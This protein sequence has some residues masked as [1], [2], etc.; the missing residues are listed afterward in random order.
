MFTQ[1]YARN[2][3][4]I[5]LPTTS[6]Y[7]PE[8]YVI[9][10]WTATEGD[11]SSPIASAT[12][13]Q[14]RTLYA[15]FSKIVY[16]DFV[17][18][19]SSQ[20]DWSGFYLIVYEETSVAYD[21]SLSSTYLDNTPNTIGV[22]ITS[23]TIEHNATTE[24]SM[25]K[26]EKNNSNY[27]IRSASGYYI[28]RTESSN[29]LDID[30]NTKYNHTISYSNNVVSI[31]SSGGPTLQFLKSGDNSKFRY[32]ASTQKAVALYKASVSYEGAYTHIYPS[33]A[34]A[35]GDINVGSTGPM[36]IENGGTLNM[37][38]NTLTCTDPTKLVIEDG[39]QLILK[40][41]N[42]NVQA[43][44]KK[45]VKTW[46]GSVAEKT[47]PVNDGWQTISTST[48][49][50][51]KGY[52]SFSNVDNLVYLDNTTPRYNVYAYDEANILW[53][54]NLAS[55]P[56]GFSTLNVGQGYIYRTGGSTDLEYKG[57]VNTGNIEV[58][59][60]YGCATSSFKGFNLIGNP[61]THTIYKGSAVS[62]IPNGTLLEE[63]YYA[64]NLATGTFD[65]TADGT[66]I[67]RGTAIMVQ[68]IKQ[69]DVYDAKD[70]TLTIANSVNGASGGKAG[71]DNIWFS[72]KNEDF[73]DFACVKF[74]PGRGLNKIDHYNET[75]PMLYINHNGE[76]FGAVNMSDDTKSINLNFKAMTMGKYTL[77]LKPEGNF[78]YIHLIDKLTG[79]DIDM[80]LEGE[81]SFIASPSDA[82]NRFIV[83]LGYQPD[84][85]NDN[86]I[87][88]Y[89]SGSDI[90]VTGNGELQ[91]FDITGRRVMTTTINGAESISIPA[92]GV[93][94]FK[95]NEKVQKIVVR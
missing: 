40:N 21:G 24:A 44:V 27:T 45:S 29:G 38:D 1:K 2:N 33:N 11:V 87:F 70:Y 57:Y 81:Y 4:T 67:P 5:T 75:A 7:V 46:T 52:V 59:L 63:G 85:G 43:T 48:H 64:L 47:D 65:L 53:V 91:I 56:Y 9:I 36:V 62:A 92:Q 35:T 28:G 39:A 13:S 31:T 18:V 6:E 71:N 83:K 34:T 88:A 72:V 25:F 93:Y 14:D 10:G 86:D 79:E 89:Q 42:T 80:L 78:T 77:S 16:G 19:T 3:A 8:G 90:Y 15:V 26:I 20:S 22:T 23:S 95:L 55:A 32:Y 49:D 69:G 54:N 84:N 51:G 61:Y 94:I 41:T 68:A 66:A 73:Q 12:A 58:V 50:D 76:N 17:K 37:G 82:D 30:A 60:G 74:K